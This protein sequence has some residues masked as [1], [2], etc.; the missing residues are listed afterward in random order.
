MGFEAPHSGVH[1]HISGAMA[2]PFAISMEED[3]DVILR[4]QG[5][6]EDGRHRKGTEHRGSLPLNREEAAHQKGGAEPR[7]S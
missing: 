4:E 2:L 3:Q 6:P 1:S 5:T 7:Q